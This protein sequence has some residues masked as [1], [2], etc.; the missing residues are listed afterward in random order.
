MDGEDILINYKKNVQG[1]NYTIVQN[2]QL[3]LKESNSLT[4]IDLLL[5]GMNFPNQIFKYIESNFLDYRCQNS[6]IDL[7][8]GLIEWL[9]PCDITSVTDMPEVQIL[10]DDSS[11]NYQ[12]H[13]DS[14]DYFLYPYYHG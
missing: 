7:E 3:F 6:S 14:K 5:K 2:N 10:I 4:H 12:Y 1:L 8:M 13:F 11:S 9:C